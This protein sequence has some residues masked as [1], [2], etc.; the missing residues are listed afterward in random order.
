MRITALKKAC[1]PLKDMNNE[2]K[3]SELPPGE[4][5]RVSALLCDGAVRRRL[6]DVGLVPGTLVRCV[7][8]SPLGD[9]KAYAV[10]GKVIAIRR[11][12]ARSIALK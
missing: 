12:D 9:P 1:H 4:G 2:K 3:L 10:R 8:V 11:S 7:G 6:L 5:G